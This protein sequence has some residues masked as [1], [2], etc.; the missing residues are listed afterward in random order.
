MED[1]VNT[2]ME[3]GW[4]ASAPATVMVW[5]HTSLT[6]I[7]YDDDQALPDH[8]CHPVASVGHEAVLL[9]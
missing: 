2:P 8:A 3:A 9:A 4:T 5:G 1:T 7:P 6:V